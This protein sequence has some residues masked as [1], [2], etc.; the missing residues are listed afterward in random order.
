MVSQYLSFEYIS[1]RAKWLAFPE[2][3]VQYLRGEIVVSPVGFPKP[4]R[5]KVLKYCIVYPVEGCLKAQLGEYNFDK[6]VKELI[7]KCG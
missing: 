1:N 5:P 2:S 7:S 3:V 6:A 4:L